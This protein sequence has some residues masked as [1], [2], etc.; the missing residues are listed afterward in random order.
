MEFPPNETSINK[1]QKESVQETGSGNKKMVQGIGSPWR[2]CSL[3]ALY[4]E[5]REKRWK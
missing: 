2:T 5:A 1:G 4:E 3:G